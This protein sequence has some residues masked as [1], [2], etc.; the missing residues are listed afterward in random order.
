MKVKT[1]HITTLKPVNLPFS[2]TIT[3]NKK[4]NVNNDFWFTPT[5]QGKVWIGDISMVSL[6]SVS[7]KDDKDI[8]KMM[9]KYKTDILTD[10]RSYYTRGMSGLVEITNGYTIINQMCE[11]WNDRKDDWDK[12]YETKKEFIEELESMAVIDV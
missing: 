7:D 2:L 12:F 9:I 3:W 8:I 10:G 5:G 6:G 1:Y 4:Q 11:Y